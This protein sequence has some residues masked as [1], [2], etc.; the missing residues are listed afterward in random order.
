MNTF[1]LVIVFP[2][3]R[4][5]RLPD[6]DST[7]CLL[8]VSPRGSD[9]KKQR[10]IKGSFPLIY[11]KVSQYRNCKAKREASHRESD[12]DSGESVCGPSG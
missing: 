11:F 5:T 3:L 10:A 1:A 7:F 12:Q 2:D 6:K 4:E 8:E 9:G